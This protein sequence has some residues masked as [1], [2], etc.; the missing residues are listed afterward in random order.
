MTAT[1]VRIVRS[2]TEEQRVQLL[3]QNQRNVVSI[4]NQ[5]LEKLL[6]EINQTLN[7]GCNLSI[8]RMPQVQAAIIA[9]WTLATKLPFNAVVCISLESN[10]KGTP[11]CICVDSDLYPGLSRSY[12]IGEFGKDELDQLRD[13]ILTQTAR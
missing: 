2:L 7:L 10:Q 8:E 6:S 11:T 9:R 3:L 13:S 5:K 4:L 1:Q 12:F